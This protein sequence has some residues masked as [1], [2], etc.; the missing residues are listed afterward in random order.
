MRY[1]AYGCMTSALRPMLTA[2]RSDAI[3]KRLPFA[4]L[5]L[6]WKLWI[7]VAE[8]VAFVYSPGA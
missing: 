6:T 8:E 1:P 3:R 4:G 7:V 2:N 5:L